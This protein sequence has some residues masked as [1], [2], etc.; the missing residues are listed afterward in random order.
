MKN[1]LLLSALAMFACTSYAQMDATAS[2]CKEK[3]EK[4][5]CAMTTDGET[6]KTEKACCAMTT[7]GETEKTNLIDNVDLSIENISCDIDCRSD[8]YCVG[9]LWTTHKTEYCVGQKCL[10][11]T[12]YKCNVCGEK[13]WIYHD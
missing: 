8:D 13:W 11:R 7:D 6:E 12:L 1:I 9:C 3:T 2:S 5:C 10:T 4:A